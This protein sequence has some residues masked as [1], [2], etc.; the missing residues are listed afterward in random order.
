MKLFSKDKLKQF[1]VNEFTRRDL[2]NETSINIT[3]ALINASL[4]GIDSHGVRLFR[5]YIDCLD[6]GRI[7]N[8]K[9]N[10]KRNHSVV[11]CDANNSFAH[12][13]AQILLKELNDKS[14]DHPIQMGVIL[15]SDHYGASGIHAYNSKIKNKLIISFTN[16]DALAN[17]PDG[18]SVV[19]G[20]NPISL[21][22]RD[23]TDR[24]TKSFSRV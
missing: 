13:A 14:E 23:E 15:N 19:F 2:S 22:Y 8:A 24:S 3:D 6:N 16:A 18:K 12:N 4:M 7:K 10:I 21:I 1:F 9:V 5:H 17:S 11:S 20:T